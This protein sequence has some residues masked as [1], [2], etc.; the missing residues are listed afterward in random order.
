MDAKWREN[1][2]ERLISKIDAS[3][4]N[5]KGCHFWNEI[6]YFNQRHAG[7]K[8]GRLKVTFPNGEKKLLLAH[9]FMY[10]LHFNVTDLPGSMDVSHL[11]HNSLCINPLHLSLE[12]KHVNASRKMCTSTIPLHCL[13]HDD[14]SDCIL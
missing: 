2:L 6:F 12:P 4:A 3:Q 1:Q 8:Y 9:R 14:Y 10:M 5:S 11:C 13:H 7:P